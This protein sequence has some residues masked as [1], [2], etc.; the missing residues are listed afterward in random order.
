MADACEPDFLYGNGQ[1][2][3]NIARVLADSALTITKKLTY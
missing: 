2:G 1:A 3:E